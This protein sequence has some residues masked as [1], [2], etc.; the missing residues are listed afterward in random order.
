LERGGQITPKAVDGPN[1]EAGVGRQNKRFFSEKVNC[2]NSGSSAGLRDW[3]S[4]IEK[5]AVGE[6]ERKW[7]ERHEAQKSELRNE[8]AIATPQS[9]DHQRRIQTAS[10]RDLP[11]EVALA[12]RPLARVNRLD[13]WFRSVLFGQLKPLKHGHLIVHDADG[14]HE[15]GDLTNREG[16]SCV[17]VLLRVADPGV[18]RRIV[19]D[20][21]LGFAEGMIEGQWSTNNLIGLMRLLI[22]HLRDVDDRLS[23]Q[24]GLRRWVSNL[25][26]WW[27]RNTRSNSRR[28]I[29]AHYDL[30]NEFFAQWLDPTMSYSCGVFSDLQPV[31]TEE[32]EEWR[33]G[34]SM[35]EAS[36]AKLD[37]ICRHLR[38][39]SSDHLVE[40]GCGWGGM[41]IHA[42]GQYG[43]RVTGVT[44]SA[45]QLEWANQ[46]VAEAGLSDRVALRLM[47]YR[48]LE[49]QY[50]KLVSVEM[51]EAV[52][53]QYLG[54]YFAKCQQLLRPGGRMV[55]QGI[56]FPDHC[57][58]D[59]LNQVDFIREYIFPGGCLI[60]LANVMQAVANMT[61]FR[62]V[63][64]REISLHYAETLR[65]WR[66]QLHDRME[67]VKP[68]G[69]DDR[70]LRMWDYYLA[71]CEAGF[72]EGQVGTVQ[73]VL[74]RPGR[75]EDWGL[76]P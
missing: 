35:Q 72:A 75:I 71:Y 37:L 52:G 2:M 73:M 76:L 18:Y 19:A 10:E 45:A 30:S 24:S 1:G 61:D 51:I 49:G 70:F 67:E 28:N 66:K 11:H 23:R 38:L 62:L 58:R 56:T 5:L 65:R 55:L 68:L 43:C 44:L 16:E 48:D 15:F 74:D 64:L 27:K 47:D 22:R 29:R 46:R 42:A 41:A 53:H 50:D 25:R 39:G 63:H 14:F 9:T 32:G 57:Y 31:P 8:P 60:S 69:F 26:H 4:S 20:G 59:Y 3:Q 6:P 17:P 54:D 36:A 33:S 40:I 7:G 12:N 13:R 21:D 34:L